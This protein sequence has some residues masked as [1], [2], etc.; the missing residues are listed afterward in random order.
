MLSTFESAKHLGECQTPWR[1]P[2]TLESGKYL[3]RVA[4]NLKEWQA[5]WRVV[6][7]L[8]SGKQLGKHLVLSTLESAKHLGE[9]YA[10]WRVLNTLEEC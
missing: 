5:P 3:E 8:K 1:V 7:T 9:C 6:S 4:S 2:S 10:P